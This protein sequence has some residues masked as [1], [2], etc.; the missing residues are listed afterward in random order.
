MGHIAIVSVVL[1]CACV[2]LAGVAWM[3][4]WSLG[5]RI[6]VGFGSVVVYGAVLVAR[7]DS[8]VL[9]DASEE[10]IDQFYTGKRAAAAGDHTEW[11]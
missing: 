4:D 8:L 5:R 2:V 9:G 7:P 1:L 6:G 10:Y 3:R 11:M